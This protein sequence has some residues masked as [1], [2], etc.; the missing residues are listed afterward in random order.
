MNQTPNML[1]NENGLIASHG[2]ERFAVEMVEVS[3]CDQHKID[4][5]Q[6]VDLHTGLLDAFDDFE[7]LGPIG[8]N[9]NAV[10]GRLNQ[11]RGMTDPCDADLSL[12]EFRENGLGKAPLGFGEE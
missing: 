6:V 4:G 10:L 5:R 7:P 11:E 2:T 8:I 3:V 12:L 1:R 9:Q